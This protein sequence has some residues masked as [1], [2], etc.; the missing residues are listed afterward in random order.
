[1]ISEFDSF[2]SAGLAEAAQVI[3]TVSFTVQGTSYRNAGILDQFTSSRELEIGGFSGNFDA[4]ILCLRS[5]F[6]ETSGTP[7]ERTLD[8]KT[9]VV[10]GRTF[11]ISRVEMD[12]TSVTFGLVNQR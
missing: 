4:T 1:M 2:M 7:L 10:D 9:L 11:T 3:G 6:T 12:E 5:K 8:G